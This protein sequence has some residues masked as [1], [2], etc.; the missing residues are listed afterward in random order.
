MRI[1]Q[2]MDDHVGESE[3]QYVVQLV[4]MAVVMATHQS[5]IGIQNGAPWKEH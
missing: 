5:S 4:C 3:K 1:S 2:R